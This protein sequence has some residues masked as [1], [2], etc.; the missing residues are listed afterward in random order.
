[1]DRKVAAKKRSPKK[2]S[3]TTPAVPKK[4]DAPKKAAVLKRVATSK[5]VKATTRGSH[6]PN[7]ETV[8]AIRDI[9]EGQNVT[10]HESAADLFKDLG[11]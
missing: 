8:R 5:G 11:I 9:E 10:H 6:V 7:A 3:P 1:M 4:V 2:P